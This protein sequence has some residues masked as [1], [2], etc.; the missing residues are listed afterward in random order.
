MVDGEPRPL[1]TAVDEFDGDMA[2]LVNRKP[3]L[4]LVI[5]K[6]LHDKMHKHEVSV[7]KTAF[8]AHF[9][10]RKIFFSPKCFPETLRR[11]LICRA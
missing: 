6:T 3:F 5:V 4:T 7:I 10:A 8:G 11:V 1:P 9:R 2:M